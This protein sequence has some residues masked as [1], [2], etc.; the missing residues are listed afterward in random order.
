[1]K[2]RR[3]PAPTSSPAQA[4]HGPATTAARQQ[5]GDIAPNAPVSGWHAIVLAGERPGGNALA[6]ALGLP[7]AVLAPLA[8]VP[9][10]QRVVDAL[11]RSAT[12]AHITLCGPAESVA[13]HS[14]TVCGLVDKPEVDWLAPAAGPAA[15]ALAGAGLDQAPGSPPADATRGFPKLLT[16]GDHG[17]LTAD[18]VDEFCARA[19]AL[20]ADLVVG[21]VPYG[22]VADAFP[23][24]RRTRLRFADGERCGSNLFAL[25]TPESARALTFWQGVEADRKQPWRIV[26]RLGVSALL[27]Y[28]LGRLSA[29]AAFDTL[30]RRAGCRIRWIGVDAARAAVDVDSAADWRLADRILGDEARNG[31]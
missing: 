15:S 17:L 5:R 25:L 29:D 16:T 22:L 7:A 2:H 13:R 12:V 4:D 26:R 1:M 18:I 9:C 11:Q 10:L 3:A 14:E 28:L 19:Q 20:D 31:A 23:E 27:R 24:S 8:G 6:R 30:S 21:L